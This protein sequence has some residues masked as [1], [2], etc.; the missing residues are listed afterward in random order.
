VRGEDDTTLD[1]A[2]TERRAILL[3]SVLTEIE[4]STGEAESRWRRDDWRRVPIDA[5][6]RVG[7]DKQCAVYQ[8]DQ[9]NETSTF[10]RLLLV[11]LAWAYTYDV[12]AFFYCRTCK[13]QIH[14]Q[15]RPE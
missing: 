11:V 9:R 2:H 10:T 5:A 7:N 13:P 8:R 3:P 4:A 15:R 6:Q 1:A 14:K 12:I